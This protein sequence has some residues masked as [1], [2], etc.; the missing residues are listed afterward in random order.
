M[1]L[2][3]K[4]TLIL[5][6][7]CALHFTRLNFDLELTRGQVV[8]LPMPTGNTVDILTTDYSTTENFYPD[9]YMEAEIRS[10]P[11]R[12][13]FAED[14]AKKYH[15]VRLGFFDEFA[16]VANAMSVG[17]V[18]HLRNVAFLVDDFHGRVKGR[19]C[20]YANERDGMKDVARVIPGTRDHDPQYMNFQR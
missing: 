14:L 9:A 13:S 15:V 8:A 18:Y 2:D 3:G 17:E 10:T 19:V 6:L 4:F 7:R 20:Y 1:Q 11:R 12:S 5:S 16:A